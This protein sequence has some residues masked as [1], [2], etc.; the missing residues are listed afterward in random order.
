[1]KIADM[2]HK[3]RLVREACLPG[4]Y[5][6][7]LASAILDLLAESAPCGWEQPKAIVGDEDGPWINADWLFKEATPDDARAMARMLLVAADEAD[8]RASA[9]AEGESE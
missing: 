3:A 6:R 1:M 5:P 2:I 8:T 4:S 9:E 7:E